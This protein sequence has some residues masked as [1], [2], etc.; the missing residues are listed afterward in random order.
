MVAKPHGG[1]LVNKVVSGRRREALVEEV[2]QLPSIGLANEV[3]VDVENIAHG[4]LSPLEGFMTQEDYLHVLQEMRLSNDVPWT[5]PITLDVDPQEV[6]GVSEGDD[7]SLTYEGRP[8]AVMKVEEIYRWDRR[9]H[10]LKVYGTLD[11]G[12]PGVAETMMRKELLLGGPIDLISEVPNPFEKY[13]LRPIETRVLFREKGWKT[14]VAFQTRNA[15]HMGHEYVQKAA[16][17]FAD[18]LFIN[19]LMGKKKRGDFKDEVILSAYEALVKHYFPRE[20]V[21]LAVLRT[22]MR[23][24]GPREAIHHSI[25]R[26][27]FGC[28]HIIIG[29]DHAG[30]G[31][32]YHPYAAWEIFKEFPDLGITPLFIRE[33]F[34]CVRCG[35]MVNEKICPHGEGDRLYLS[36]TKI[37]EMLMRRER[38]PEHV[39]RP[40]VVNA[41]LNYEKPFIE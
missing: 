10:A 22:E 5:I 35:G 17:T 30:V 2:A 19:P 39:M 36:G 28:T 11:P 18:G 20:A 31:S 7:V 13:T 8:L 32:F 34:Y 27:N 16:L 21:V 37:R 40:E 1:R 4:V 6:K 25:M 26:K 29:R 3:A 38:P 24:A 14:I 9:E 41:I 23:Y 33:S 15:P 12:H